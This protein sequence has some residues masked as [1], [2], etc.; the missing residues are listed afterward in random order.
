MGAELQAM[1]HKIC[2]VLWIKIIPEHF[3]IKID[4]P[5]K[6]FG[7]NWPEISIAHDPVQYD[8]MTDV[9]STCHFRKEKLH[10]SHQSTVHIYSPEEFLTVK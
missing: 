9:E 3:Q 6:Q 4:E 10:P 5:S 2:E 8:H 7:R 1:A